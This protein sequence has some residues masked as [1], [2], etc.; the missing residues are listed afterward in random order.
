MPAGVFISVAEE[1]VVCGFKNR[2]N[3]RIRLKEDHLS[4]DFRP[5]PMG[6]T[7]VLPCLPEPTNTA[8]EKR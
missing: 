6:P 8:P 4:K 3:A 1:E 2:P 5:R 7:M